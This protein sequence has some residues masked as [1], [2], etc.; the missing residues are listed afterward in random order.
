MEPKVT[1]FCRSNCRNEARRDYQ[2]NNYSETTTI[3]GTTITNISALA[4]TGRTVP[5]SAT[6]GLTKAGV[7]TSINPTIGIGTTAVIA[8]TESGALLSQP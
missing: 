4:T 7:T 5:T 6:T 3:R 8:A 2:R 1:I